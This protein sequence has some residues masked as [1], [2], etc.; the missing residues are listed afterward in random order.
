V[1]RFLSRAVLALL[2]ASML[3]CMVPADLMVERKA[4]R[5]QVAAL[6]ASVP[7]DVPAIAEALTRAALAEERYGQ[8]E[9]AGRLLGR[10]AQLLSERAN[11]EPRPAALALERAGRNALVRRSPQEAAQR[12]AQ[13]ASVLDASGLRGDPLWVDV[14]RELAFTYQELGD[15]AQAAEHLRA[16]GD[17]D[18]QTS[19]LIRVE[20]RYPTWAES[21]G[22]QGWVVLEVTIAADGSVADARVRDAWPGDLFHEVALDAVRK[23]RYLPELVDGRP[24]T[25]KGLKVRLEFTPKVGSRELVRP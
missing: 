5:Q 2:L 20:P 6:E 4:Y 24:V 11:V 1:T 3:A 10:A 12:Y 15:P 18:G 22:M 19:L 7:R 23:W 25:R 21:V 16:V 9:E 14:Q 13:A 8:L 17:A